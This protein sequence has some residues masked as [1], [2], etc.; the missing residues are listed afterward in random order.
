MEPENKNSKKT[1]RKEAKQE[2]MWKGESE[3]DTQLQRGRIQSDSCLTKLC[4]KV[5]PIDFLI[6]LALL[7]CFALERLYKA[8]LKP[9]E[10]YLFFLWSRNIGPSPEVVELSPS[11]EH[12]LPK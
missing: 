7:I 6:H 9:C 8:H 1:V 5:H 3:S 11:P 4:C 2:G 12:Q 10:I